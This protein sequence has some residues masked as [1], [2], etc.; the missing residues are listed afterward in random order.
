MSPTSTIDPVTTEVVA[1]RLREIASTMEYALYHAG[2]SPILRESKDGTAGLVDLDGRVV[3]I[4]GGL[5]YHSLPYEK[6][7][8]SVVARY[9]IESMV[10]GETFIVNDPYQGGNPHVPDMIVVTPAFHEGK[11]IGYGASIAHKA[12][13]GGLVPGSSGAAAREIYHDGLLLPP[14][15][16]M[17]KDGIN[18]IVEA[19]IRSNSRVPD[20]VLGDLRGQAGCTRIGAERL[21]AL[22]DEYGRDVVLGVMRAMIDLAARRTRAEIATWADG[23][24]EAEGFLDHDAANPDKPVRIAVKAT[25]KGDKLILD[26]SGCSPQTAGPVNMNTHTARAVS[27]LA[28]LASSDPT[29]PMNSGTAEAVEFVI[30]EGLVVSPRHPAT[31]NHYFPTSHLLYNCVLSA[32]GQLNPKRAVAPSGLGCGA[33]AIG[34]EQAR[35]G[36][37]AVQYE[38]VITA[39]GGTSRQDGSTIV[40]PMNHITP[41]APVEIVESEYPVRVRRFDLW[42]D[43]AGAGT[44]RGGLGYVRDY[45]LLTDVIFTARTSNHRFSAWGANGG[46]SPRTSRTTV[47]PDG[48]DRESLGPIESRRLKAGDVLRLER[49]GGAGYGDPLKRDPHSVLEDVRN[50]YVSPAAAAEAYGVVIDAALSLDEAATEARRAKMRANPSAAQ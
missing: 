32:L 42:T 38:I 4:S 21:A 45:E 20:V 26:L 7:V 35:S 33:I 15:R 5:Q 3:M 37:R 39:L 27:L 28:V 22:C 49:S 19:I 34:Y 6:A 40:Q 17:T 29:I 23:E 24:A 48:P 12:D 14:V 16:Y 50:G 11:L 46:Q 36:K 13:V 47:N 30:P 10:P 2:Y 41:G 18:E 44:H 31:I 9:P 1:S 25:K 8:K 43:S